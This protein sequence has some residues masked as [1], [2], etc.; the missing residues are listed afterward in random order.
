MEDD[1]GPMRTPK[2]FR[3]YS[4]RKVRGVVRGCHYAELNL[5]KVKPF[6]ITQ[7]SSV[8]PFVESGWPFK[9]AISNHLSLTSPDAERIGFGCEHPEQ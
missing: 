7:L 5:M 4:L 6:E 3:P 1:C 9:I 8:E 2:E